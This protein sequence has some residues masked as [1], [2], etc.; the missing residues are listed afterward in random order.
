[1]SGLNV[2]S[3]EWRGW[4]RVADASDRM[5]SDQQICDGCTDGKGYGICPAYIKKLG[6]NV[7]GGKL[8]L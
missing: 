4:K 8:Q 5:H 7:P 3:M 6:V 2:K 1:M